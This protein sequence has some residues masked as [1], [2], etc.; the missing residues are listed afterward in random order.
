MSAA[1]GLRLAARTRASR[2]AGAPAAASWAQRDARRH[3]HY[4]K[5]LPY[6]IDDGL[7]DFLSPEALKMVAVEYQDGLLERLNDQVRGAC[8][9]AHNNEVQM[10]TRTFGSRALS[11]SF[12]S[13]ALCIV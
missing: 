5:E 1:L 10:L 3:I 13:F 12:G 7:N 8:L 4:R 11:F 9:R 6:S 2:T